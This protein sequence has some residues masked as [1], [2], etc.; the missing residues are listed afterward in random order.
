[1]VFTLIVYIIEWI[2]AGEVDEYKQ[3]T[4]EPS[5]KRKRRHNKYSKEKLEARELKLKLE[6]ESNGKSLE[7][8]IMERQ[9]KRASNS[10]NFFDKLMEKYADMDDSDE[11]VFEGRSGKGKSKKT[12]KKNPSTTTAKSNENKVK[13]GRVMKTR[14]T[15]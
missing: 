12:T 10:G 3:F 2:N 1:M 6:K 13:T 15:T 5:T 14:R 7:Q 8:Q 9:N 4:E 11:Y